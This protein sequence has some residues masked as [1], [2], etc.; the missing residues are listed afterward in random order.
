[1]LRVL[2]VESSPAMVRDLMT[3]LGEVAPDHASLSCD[4]V[5]VARGLLSSFRPHVIFLEARLGEGGDGLGL[6]RDIRLRV[7]GARFIAMNGPH[8]AD[9]DAAAT[10][11]L[12]AHAS[13]E[14]P[15][16]SASVADAL[17]PH[18]VRK[19]PAT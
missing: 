8:D 14:T 5:D 11:A 2:I 6:R 4:R 15:L 19:A 10:R 1:M 18:R 16:R 13:L 7:P 3:I 12:G 17:G 9:P